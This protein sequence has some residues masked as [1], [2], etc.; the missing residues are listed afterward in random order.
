[1]TSASVWNKN[2]IT[3]PMV[4]DCLK[5]FGRLIVAFNFLSRP[6]ENFHFQFLFF[7]TNF[8]ENKMSY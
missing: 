2:A 6:N 8:V 4:A 7:N 3:Q 5:Y 1:M